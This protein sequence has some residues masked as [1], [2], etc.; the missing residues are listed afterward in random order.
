SETLQ[1]F[2]NAQNA[3]KIIRYGLFPKR[4]IFEAFCALMKACNVSDC[5][6]LRDIASF[7]QRT[8]CF[9]NN[10]LWAFPKT[11]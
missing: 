11:D 2:I 1:A 9:K 4:I 6:T 8:K 10:P 5:Q 7:H 3:S